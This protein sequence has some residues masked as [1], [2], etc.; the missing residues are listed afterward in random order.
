MKVQRPAFWIAVA[1]C[2]VTLVASLLGALLRGDLQSGAPWTRDVVAIVC[3][4]AAVCA[5]VYLVFRGLAA[6]ELYRERRAA[7][8]ER[9]HA[10]MAREKHFLAGEE[11]QIGRAHV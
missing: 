6:Q 11:M 10:E 4:V 1:A 3:L 2:C 7:E 9:R 8:V 5:A